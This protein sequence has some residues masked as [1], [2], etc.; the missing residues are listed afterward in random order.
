[1]NDLKNIPEKKTNEWKRVFSFFDFARLTALNDNFIIIRFNNKVS[2]ITYSDLEYNNYNQLY[3]Y[4]RGILFDIIEMII[5]NIRDEECVIFKYS[6][7]W[8]SN[9]KRNRKLYRIL[10]RNNIKNINSFA[11]C[12]NKSNII[13]FVDA[14]FSYNSFCGF[15]FTKDKII[16]LPSD[17]MDIFIYYDNYDWKEKIQSIINEYTDII[18]CVKC[19]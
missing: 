16:M 7:K 5:K 1:M 11:I 2:N 6:H 15:A 8:I 9:K 18:D 17:H 13:D 4:K 14:I 19:W 12:E 3:E 10:R